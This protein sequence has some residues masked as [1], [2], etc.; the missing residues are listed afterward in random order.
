MGMFSWCC[1]GCKREVVGPYAIIGLGEDGAWLNQVAVLVDLDKLDIY[2]EDNFR[3]YL[4]PNKDKNP[5]VGVLRGDYDGYGGVLGFEIIDLPM[6]LWHSH[7]WE[8]CGGPLDI[9]NMPHS[10]SAPMQGHFIDRGELEEMAKK[11]ECL[12][13]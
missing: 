12:L 11:P 10:Q 13:H 9:E 7:C 2:D 8:L 5:R 1:V 4:L 6:R 3:D